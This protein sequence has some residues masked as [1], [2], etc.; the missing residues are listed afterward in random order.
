MPGAEGDAV[1]G[2]GS[3]EVFRQ[4]ADVD[5]CSVGEGPGARRG[6][7]AEPFE[8]GA[9]VVDRVSGGAGPGGGDVGDG[10]LRGGHGGEF[11]C[12]RGGGEAGQTARAFVPVELPDATVRAYRT[13]DFGYLD[14]TGTLHFRGR[15]DR[16]LKIRGHRVE[17]AEIEAAAASVPGVRSAAA[18]PLRGPD[19][20]VTGL[21]LFYTRAEDDVEGAVRASGEP[22]PLDVHAHLT[23]VLPDYLVPTVTSAL[24][25]LPFTPNGKLD[26]AALESAA[27][28]RPCRRPAR[29]PAR[30]APVRPMERSDS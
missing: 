30:S 6:E 29:R 3:L 8:V 1:C 26:R 4:S 12:G 17:V 5:Q 24:T 18:V 19:G 23:A 2:R 21:A 14:E 7:G 25:D 20:T 10:P 13:G 28:R 27:L 15:T 11:G 16:Q 22:D 9:D